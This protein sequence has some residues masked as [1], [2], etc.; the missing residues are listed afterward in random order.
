MKRYLVIA[1]LFP[2]AAWA[3]CTTHCQ[4]ENPAKDRLVCQQICNAPDTAGGSKRSASQ[5]AVEGYY[6]AGKAKQEQ[7]LRQLELQ[8]RRLELEEMRRKLQ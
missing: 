4:Y 8:R 5:A 1:L 2:C 3:Q 6:A 7:E